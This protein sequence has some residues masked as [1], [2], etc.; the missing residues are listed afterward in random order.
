MTAT[1]I[2]V[3]QR[4]CRTISI[5]TLAQLANGQGC[6]DDDALE[7]LKGLDENDPPS[8]IGDFR[9]YAADIPAAIKQAQDD[10]LWSTVKF[11]DQTWSM[12]PRAIAFRVLETFGEQRD[13]PQ[14]SFV[15]NGFE[16][17]GP[18]LYTSEQHETWEAAV[19]HA[20]RITRYRGCDWATATITVA[21]TDDSAAAVS[22]GGHRSA[23][24]I[25]T[26][27]SSAIMQHRGA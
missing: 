26:V 1:A 24:Y 21:F 2:Y 20:R 8:R 7:A 23:Q 9:H 16:H 13:Q 27:P 25:Y 22:D 14:Y 3:T 17:D 11:A 6:S 5:R 10:V 18:T 12:F 4:H 19:D 15:T